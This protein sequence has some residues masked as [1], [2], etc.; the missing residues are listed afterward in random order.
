M[1]RTANPGAARTGA[2]VAVSW[3]AFA[4][5][6]YKTQGTF[7]TWALGL[8]LVFAI[9]LALNIRETALSRRS[10]CLLI[11]GWAGV[12]PFLTAYGSVLPAWQEAAVVFTSSL[13]LLAIAVLCWFDR[14]DL[15]GLALVVSVTTL[16]VA[17]FM[18]FTDPRIPAIDVF[19]FV[20]QAADK[21]AT[22]N[23]YGTTWR[24]INSADPVVIVQGF[25]YLPMTAVLLAP[26]R[27]L[28]GDA[29]WGL[30]LAVLV[31]GLSIALAGRR[32]SSPVVGAFL[33]LAPGTLLLIES[34][35]TETLVAGL[36]IP[37]LLAF[38]ARRTTGGV[39]LL[40]LA[41][42]TK[43]HVVLLLPL[44]AVWKVVGYRRVAVACGIAVALCLPWLIASPRLFLHD[45]VQL[46]LDLPPRPD[47]LTIYSALSRLDV[48]VPTR[49]LALVAVVI[50]GAVSV[51]VARRQ[52]ALSGV[53]AAAA[54][55]LMA[56]NLLN[57][58]AFINQYWLAS[59][60]F[61]LSIATAGSRSAED[62]FGR[63]RVYRE[64]EAGS[65][66]R[67]GHVAPEPR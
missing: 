32:V 57:S 12:Q 38:D 33:L 10:V 40:A 19:H 18:V 55:V 41:L 66:D 26:F 31:T 27:W 20:N 6:S 25:P 15:D 61:L 43:Q 53:S 4:V 49:L 29:R 51:W 17:E 58:Q 5:V 37:A 11:A 46:H 9:S 47:G 67:T 39:I 56:A 30:L 63:A 44:L 24:D 23:V 22:G 54:L 13:A 59:C 8:G 28:F 1:I 35:W 14:R 45:T 36:L 62:V 16:V 64:A 50:I 48:D 34:T 21:V 52:P 60:L 3:L 42:A 7:S 2:F 65:R